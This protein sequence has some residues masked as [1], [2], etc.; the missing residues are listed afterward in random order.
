MGRGNCSAKAQRCLGIEGAA[1][2]DS[3]MVGGVSVSQERKQAMSPGE[4]RCRQSWQET[5]L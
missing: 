5:F 1:G 4:A 3:G 2:E